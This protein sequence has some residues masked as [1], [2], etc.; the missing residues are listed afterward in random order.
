MQR[1]G[2]RCLSGQNVT[3]RN[4]LLDC[5][6]SLLACGLLGGR[7]SEKLAS[8]T[9]ESPSALPGTTEFQTGHLESTGQNIFL[10]KRAHPPPYRNQTQQPT[11]QPQP[12]S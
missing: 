10:L 6:F 11:R 3:L 8:A 12:T 2:K 9:L 1:E 4:L 7:V 5:P